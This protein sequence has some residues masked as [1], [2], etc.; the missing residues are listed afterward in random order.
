MKKTLA[1]LLLLCAVCVSGWGQEVRGG[2][3]AGMNIS[4]PSYYAPFVGAKAG[5]RGDVAFRDS[6]SSGLFEF[7]LMLNDKSWRYVYG[8]VDN[9]H[10]ARLKAHALY[11]EV[12]LHAGYRWQVG[13]NTRV[14]ITAGPYLA[15]GVAGRAKMS[16]EGITGR[17]ISETV[18]EKLFDD[19]MER[20][21][22]GLG[23]RVGIELK[24][25]MQLSIE[26]DWGMLNFDKTSDKQRYLNRILTL[27]LSYMF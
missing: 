9:I 7:G 3:T 23:Y 4:S 16:Y 20:F 5:M 2:F 13:P 21:D 14:F 12:P 1:T 11:I 24:N 18:I 6:G 19:A 15:Y 8:D 26:Q 27:S 25:E 22:C 17:R 10:D